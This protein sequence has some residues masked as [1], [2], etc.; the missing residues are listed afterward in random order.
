M[1]KDHTD[2]DH[3]GKGVAKKVGISPSPSSMSTTLESDAKQHT[4][5]M[6]SRTGGDFDK[7]YIGAQVTEHQA[8]LDL[9][10]TQLLPH[11]EAAEVKSFVQAVRSKV[12]S[13]LKEAQ[14]IQRKLGG[15]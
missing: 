6:S 7:A 1:I 9:I 10:D 5:T 14:D 12:E 3:K 8:V 15:S 4:S 11:A 2:A 13:H